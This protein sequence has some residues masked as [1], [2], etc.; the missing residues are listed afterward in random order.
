MFQDLTLP[1]WYLHN[2]GDETYKNQ[3]LGIWYYYLWMF[4]IWGAC[5]L[6]RKGVL[7]GVA[8]D[9][10]QWPL[11]PTSGNPHITATSRFEVFSILWRYDRSNLAPLLSPL[12]FWEFKTKSGLSVLSFH[13]VGFPFC[14]HRTGKT[15][16][17]DHLHPTL[18]A[19]N[20]PGYLP[21]GKTRS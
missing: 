13:T 11:S 1:Q 17:S 15:Y 4:T 20:G 5:S 9:E 10:W 6:L 3:Y 19:T 18:G 12:R 16:M 2:A 21:G 7:L 8:L 14:R